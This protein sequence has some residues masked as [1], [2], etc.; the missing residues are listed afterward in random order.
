MPPATAA[1]NATITP[2][3]RRGGKDLGAV[4]GQQRLVGGDHV[5]AGGNRFE[6]QRLGNAVAADQLDD[7]VDLGV[8]D[9][10]AASFTT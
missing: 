5:L 4:H 1:S 3:G 10:G 8:G 6:H 9:H 7:D 2:L